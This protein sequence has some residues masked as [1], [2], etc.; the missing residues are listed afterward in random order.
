VNPA[1]V[2]LAA[3]LAL[4]SLSGLLGV[5]QSVNDVTRDYRAPGLEDRR[6]N[7][8]TLWNVLEP[9]VDSPAIEVEGVGRS[10]E[11]RAIRALHFGRGSTRVLLWS[12]MHGDEST[13]TMALTDIIRFLVEGEGHPL[14]E[15]LHKE[16]T[17]TMVP[18]LN[19]DGAERFTRRNAVGVDINRD[20]RQQAT[21][22]GRAL[23]NL[24][25]R[26]EP[27]F[28]FNL[29]DQ[30]AR[31]LAGERGEQVGIALSAPAADETRSYGE[32]RSRAR[33][34]A[35]TIVAALQ[36]EI[37]GHIAKYDDTFAPRA[38][39]DL[40]QQWGTST[41]L[42]ESGAL[43]GDPDKQALRRINVLGILTALDAIA[44]GGYRDAEIELY[45]ALPEN[46]RIELDVVLRGGELVFGDRPPFRV[47]VGIWFEDPVAR[48]EPRL[49]DVGDLADSPAIE[50]I[51]ATGL[52]VRVE[53]R[54]DD[55]TRLVLD[56]PVFV[57]VSHPDGSV[58][59]R[60]G[61]RR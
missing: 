40:M 13:A 20:A 51:D 28:G 44:S 45:E 50:V 59:H 12:Q 6:F 41:V 39:G 43:R 19:P 56:T 9:F 29:H 10:I 52:V 58:V 54:G 49:G 17:I 26:I 16:L 57:E 21:P 4:L 33:L 55:R 3:P 7:H 35:A 8:E 25:D 42:I 2:V 48:E 24:R 34:V 27:Q 47:D 14:R 30:G 53:T 46:E 23:K 61:V 18:M 60:F 22:E 36:N 11:G 15:R 5:T 1:A 31:T 32:V 38:F 37:G